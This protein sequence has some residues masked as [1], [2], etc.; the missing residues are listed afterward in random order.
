VRHGYGGH[1]EDPVVEDDD[2]L[3]ADVSGRCGH[4]DVCGPDE[5]ARVGHAGVQW[6]DVQVVGVAGQDVLDQIRRSGDRRFRVDRGLAVE[7]GI[8]FR[9]RPGP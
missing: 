4:G 5:R 1:L 9:Q 3:R 7:D 8:T 2:R 6:H